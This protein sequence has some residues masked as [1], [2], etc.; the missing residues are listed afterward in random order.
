MLT[1]VLPSS[2]SFSHSCTFPTAPFQSPITTK[3]PR[4]TRTP[5][6]LVHL[7]Y[8]RKG[9]KQADVFLY[10]VNQGN[11]IVLRLNPP[12]DLLYTRAISVSHLFF[13]R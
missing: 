1:L 3:V 11:Q 4:E 8:I 10:A 9:G 13:I 6:H 7:D 2:T 12:I 5:T